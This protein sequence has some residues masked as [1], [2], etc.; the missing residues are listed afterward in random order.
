M[1]KP[2]KK[3]KPTKKKASTIIRFPVTPAGDRVLVRRTPPHE[4]TPLPP[5]FPHHKTPPPIINK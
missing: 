5:L 2:I 1:K 3:K 4:M